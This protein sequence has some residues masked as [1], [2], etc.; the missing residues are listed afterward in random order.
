MPP[1]AAIRPAVRM[2]LRAFNGAFKSIFLKSKS[3]RNYPPRVSPPI[4]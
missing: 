4:F 3:K 1:E 2:C